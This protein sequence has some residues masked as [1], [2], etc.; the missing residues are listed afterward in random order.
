MLSP[1]PPA[2]CANSCPGESKARN[3]I[4]VKRIRFVMLQLP[5][6][7]IRSLYLYLLVTTVIDVLLT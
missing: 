2:L 5:P 4:A 1:S 3:T 7:N 6:M